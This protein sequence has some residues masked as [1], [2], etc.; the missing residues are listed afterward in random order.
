MIEYLQIISEIMI[1]INIYFDLVKK[2]KIYK[3]FRSGYI[4]SVKRIIS[5]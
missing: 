1:I 5:I 2:I 3:L 4:Q